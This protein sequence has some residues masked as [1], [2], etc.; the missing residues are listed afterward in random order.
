M[1]KKLLALG[2]ALL[3]GTSMAESR[4]SGFYV[5]VQGG[6]NLAQFKI[7]DGSSHEG[8]T[9]TYTSPGKTSYAQNGTVN[10]W[11]K[12][13]EGNTQAVSFNVQSVLGNNDAFEATEYIYK[14][15]PMAQF[16]AGYN[17]QIGSNFVVGLELKAGAVFG[18]HKF[19]GSAKVNDL[20]SW[21]VEDT[22]I[23]N[24]ENPYYKGNN[25]PTTFELKT[26]FTGDASLRLG[27]I[28]PGT[29]GRLA[30]FLRG[31]IGI[32][33]QELTFKQ[34]SGDYYQEAIMQSFM[35]GAKAKKMELKGTLPGSSAT[36]R[37]LYVGACYAFENAY[38]SWKIKK[39]ANWGIDVRLNDTKANILN[40]LKDP[41]NTGADTYTEL[42]DLFA[43]TYCTD[44]KGL[45][46]SGI[47]ANPD[48]NE[49][50]NRLTGHAGADL[51]YHFAS[52]MFVRASY[53]FNYIKGFFAESSAK[54][55]T[56]NKN[57]VKQI[58][59]NSDGAI[60]AFIKAL[61]GTDS[62]VFTNEVP[63]NDFANACENF[64]KRLYTTFDQFPQDGINAG[65]MKYKVGTNKK[66]FSHDFS[67]GIGYKFFG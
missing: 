53:T 16:F 44:S 19:D 58:I 65:T 29:E 47:L 18:A 15:R 52:G 33:R 61:E 59:K 28:V 34:T 66:S 8:T 2:A 63:G 43:A 39:T 11:I 9:A 26:K 36:D 67:L 32:A 38:M 13:E 46:V 7:F 48:L 1:S 20:T 12:V 37:A 17:Y 3:M 22:K 5:G 49:T 56:L 25:R 51:E 14:V 60:A 21:S 41:N 10:T 6:M 45:S 40:K 62:M 42:S 24:K 55:R 30:F 23:I 35:S 64:E 31:G 50:K 4:V 57:E 27:Y 54:S